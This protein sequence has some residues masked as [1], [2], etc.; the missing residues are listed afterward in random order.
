MGNIIS[1]IF[2]IFRDGIQDLRDIDKQLT[3][4]R[5]VTGE[6]MET[7]REYAFVANE[8]AYR[9]GATTEKVI[10]QATAW[11]R[12][13]YSIQNASHLAEE[14]IILSVVGNMQIDRATTNLVATLRG[15][16]YEVK[17]SRDI[18]DMVNEVGNRYAISQEEI[19]EILKR[20]SA[21]MMAANNS[22]AETIALGT[23]AQEVQQD[24]ARVGTALRTVSMRIRGVSEEGEDLSDLVPTL[25]RQ[26]SALGLTL[27]EDA[28]TFHSTY[29]I[30]K[31]LSGVWDDITDIQRADILESVAGKNMPPCMVTYK[32]KFLLINWRNP[33]VKTRIIHNKQECA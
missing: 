21:A 13:G 32:C 9:L 12:L 26:F 23:G 7:M 22:L 31:D 1:S 19:T 29:K 33:N 2:R 24:A 3:E 27:L 10:E 16:N 15:F 28:D 6:S 17:E 14:S 18:I 4:L 11:A 5:K 25:E 8:T 30:L 20:S